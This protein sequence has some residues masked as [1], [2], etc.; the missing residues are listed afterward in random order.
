MSS[1]TKPNK[2][3]TIEQKI[4]QLENL[5]KQ[6]IQKQKIIERKARTKRLCARMGLFESMLPDSINLTDEQFK[7]LLEK[8]AASDFGKRTLAKLATMKTPKSSDLPGE[9]GENI[10]EG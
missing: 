1:P 2:I 3:T 7:I 5:R 4:K 10:G 9:N 8:T 6:E